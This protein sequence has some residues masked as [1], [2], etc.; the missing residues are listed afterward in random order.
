MQEQPTPVELEQF[1][2]NSLGH[3]Y[4]AAMLH[5]HSLN[6]LIRDILAGAIPSKFGNE[7]RMLVF[8]S[9]LER[10]RIGASQPDPTEKD[11]EKLLH[12]IASSRASMRTFASL[13]ATVQAV[14]T[15]LRNI[16]LDENATDIELRRAIVTAENT[17]HAELEPTFPPS[18]PL[19]DDVISRCYYPVDTPVEQLQ[20]GDI[21]FTPKRTIKAKT[22]ELTEP[23]PKTPAPDQVFPSRGALKVG[24][25]WRTWGS[26]ETIFTTEQPTDG[27][28]TKVIAAGAKVLRPYG[29]MG[30]TMMRMHY[31]INQFRSMCAYEQSMGTNKDGKVTERLHLGRAQGLGVAAE[32]L[33]CPSWVLPAIK[34]KPNG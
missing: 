8:A 7:P 24:G 32:T 28:I 20:E 10:L 34:L 23:A 2:R 26:A 16:L 11:G 13:I 31:A 19:S 14:M 33:T 6:G 3:A 17:L 30:V 18:E 4:F 27:E 9:E 12:E 1:T 22:P 29:E 21:V 5:V 25:I 15:T